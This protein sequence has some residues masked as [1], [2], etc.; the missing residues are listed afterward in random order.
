[1]TSFIKKI[2]HNGISRDLGYIASDNFN[3][4]IYPLG[5]AQFLET[6]ILLVLAKE[7]KGGEEKICLF[8]N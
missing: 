1:M 2:H 7:L 4:H 5:Y 3:F 8:L 6:Y